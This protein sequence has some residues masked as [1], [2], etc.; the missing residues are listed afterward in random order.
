MAEAA[1]R[2]V[3]FKGAH[4][5]AYRCRDA[6]QTRWFY[7]DAMGLPLAAALVIEAVPGTHEDTPYMHLFFGLPDG[8]Y[9]AFFDEPE[10]I[11]PKWF[12]MKHGFDMHYAFEAESEEAMLAMKDRMKEAGVQVFGPIDHGFVRSVYMY[13]PNGIQIEFTYRTAKHDPIMDEEKAHARDAIADWVART[14]EAK[15]AKFGEEALNRRG[16]IA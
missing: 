15:V 2:Q 9:I 7:E 8:N 10:K 13:D 14:R 4:H 3:P 12:D 16:R 5:V 11:D 6:E 1:T